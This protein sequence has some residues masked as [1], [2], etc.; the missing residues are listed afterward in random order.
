MLLGDLLHV[1]YEEDNFSMRCDPCQYLH[2]D[3]T[4]SLAK[5]IQHRWHPMVLWPALDLFQP[6]SF[7]DFIFLVVFFPLERKWGN[8]VR[9]SLQGSADEECSMAFIAAFFLPHSS[10]HHILYVPLSNGIPCLSML[11]PHW[12]GLKDAAKILRSPLEPFLNCCHAGC[13]YPIP[14]IY[15]AYFHSFLEENKSPVAPSAC[16]KQG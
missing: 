3:L 14:V 5:G 9:F 2:D 16:W 15:S 8:K 1:R 12:P 6:G 4:L 7:L 10:A 13:G 11:E